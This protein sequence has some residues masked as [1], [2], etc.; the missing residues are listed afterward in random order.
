MRIL[1]EKKEY[2][3]GENK[4]TSGKV[5]SNGGSGRGGG[6]DF[7]QP[8]FLDFPHKIL[9]LTEFSNKCFCRRRRLPFDFGYYRTGG[10]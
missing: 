5:V 9:A 3:H 10:I 6:D 4:G 2:N 1:V 8:F 7:H